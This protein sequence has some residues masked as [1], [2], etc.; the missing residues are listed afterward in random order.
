MNRYAFATLALLLL[1]VLALAGSHFGPGL[2]A[3]ER[4]EI[5]RIQVHLAGAERVLEGRDLALLTPTQKQARAVHVARLREYRARG[6]FPHN[7]DFRERRPFFVDE[8]GV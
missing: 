4:L 2:S 6:V 5:D 8:H 3:T 1:V 7:H